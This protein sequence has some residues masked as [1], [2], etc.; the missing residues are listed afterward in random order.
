MQLIFEQTPLSL[1]IN[2]KRAKLRDI[3][4]KVV[5][6]KL[7]MNPSRIRHGAAFLYEVG[8]GLNAAMKINYESNLDKV[9]FL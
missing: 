9:W 4:E 6:N 5:K 1:E 3:V 7:G 8:T 2:T